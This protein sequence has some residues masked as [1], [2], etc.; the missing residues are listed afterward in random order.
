MIYEGT[1]AYVDTE[2]LNE[3]CMF[4]RQVIEEYLSSD[5]FAK[6][7]ADGLILG[8]TTHKFRNGAEETP[9]YGEDDRLLD[10]GVITHC[11]RKIW[12]DGNA[13]RAH[14]EIFDDLNDYAPDEQ[15]KIMQ[16]LRLVKHRINVPCS[17]VT[18][19]DW[20]KENHMAYLYD[21]IGLDFTL[22]PAAPGSKIDSNKQIS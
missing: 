8:T 19:A 11:V 16:L 13:I 18:D 9:G 2:T 3:G 12:I 20:D 7:L 1:I 17:I 6:R 5:R 10:E 15:P 4:P 14:I 22:N 21:L